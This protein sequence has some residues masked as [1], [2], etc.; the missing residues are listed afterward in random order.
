MSNHGVMV[1]NNADRV[2]KAQI[3]FNLNVKGR[4]Q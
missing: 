4:L 2:C 3:A 1:E